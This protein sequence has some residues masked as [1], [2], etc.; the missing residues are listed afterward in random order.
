VIHAPPSPV[1]DNEF[2]Y[3]TGDFTEWSANDPAASVGPVGAPAPVEIPNPP[4]IPVN[5]VSHPDG[6]PLAIGLEEALHPAAGSGGYFELPPPPEFDDVAVESVAPM[7]LQPDSRIEELIGQLQ[8]NFDGLH[9]EFAGLHSLFTEELAAVQSSRKDMRDVLAGLVE[10]TAA[11]EQ[12][13]P[14]IEYEVTLLLMPRRGEARHGALLLISEH[15]RDANL[16]IGRRI[17]RETR[18]ATCQTDATTLGG[19]LRQRGHAQFQRH[20][21]LHV[22]QQSVSEIDLSQ[23]L[24]PG[25]IQARGSRIQERINTLPWDGSLGIRASTS[26]SGLLNV[27]LRID[28]TEPAGRAENW[29]LATLLPGGT[30][31]LTAVLD[32]AYRPINAI[33]SHDPGSVPE[34]AV[35][36]RS[37]TTEI[38]VLIQPRVLT[39]HTS[40]PPINSHRPRPFLPE[41]STTP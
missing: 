15:A 23:S 19:W 41:E 35:P 21:A 20:S 10:A 6:S 8:T 36:R 27:E 7:Q 37:S 33:S 26:P 2:L 22:E 13:P 28:S 16:S 38:I 4:R 24:A 29:T 32:E 5:V 3:S 40:S 18:W 39:T 9:N 30:L 31:I 17:A 1:N 14:P 11:R 12:A 34:Q 25:M